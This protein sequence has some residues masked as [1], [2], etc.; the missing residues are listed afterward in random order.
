MKRSG[1]YT[2]FLL[3]LKL[4][5]QLIKDFFNVCDFKKKLVEEKQNT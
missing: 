2:S 1:I 3:Y 5:S 4:E